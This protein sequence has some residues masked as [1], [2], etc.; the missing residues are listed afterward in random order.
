MYGSRKRKRT[1][2]RKYTPS[3]RF[4]RLRRS[5]ATRRRK[6]G[7]SSIMAPDVSSTGGNKPKRR[8]QM[9]PRWRF[10]KAPFPEKVQLSFIYNDTG[11]ELNPNLGNGYQAEHIFRGNSVYDPDYT[12]YGVQPYWHDKFEA[13]YKYYYVAAS[14]ISIYLYNPDGT[15]LM[16]HYLQPHLTATTTL[17]GET[18]NDLLQKVRMKC[19][20]CRWDAS[21][22]HTVSKI[23][24]YCP[25][26]FFHK[27]TDEDDMYTAFGDNP[28]H[29]FYW[30]YMVDTSIVAGDVTVKFDVKIKYYCQ[31]KEKIDDETE[32]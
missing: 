13:I 26:A 23:S 6:L 12:G 4:P 3:R 2:K 18:R 24:S 16:Y 32:N 27:A 29:A 1:Y 22:N 7:R 10:G 5:K 20:P 28:L 17:F 30:H 21:R 14:K 25:T 8:V 19:R 9:V 15:R 31:L 11:F